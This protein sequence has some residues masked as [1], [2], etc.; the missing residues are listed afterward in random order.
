MGFI[1]SMVGSGIS[2]SGAM[3]KQGIGIWDAETDRRQAKA[4]AKSQQRMMEYNA[5][6]ERR[7]AETV[8]KEYNEQARRL[9]MESENTK[10]A[11]RAGYGKSGV[12]MDSGSPL[13]VMADTSAYLEMEVQDTHRQGERE[14]SKHLVNAQNFMYQARVAKA[15]APR[16]DWVSIINNGM[17]DHVMGVGGA[18]QGAGSTISS[19]KK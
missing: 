5:R 8:Q 16:R 13:A 11:Q 9:R 4:N 12:A 6:L 15:S 17:A 10:S 14:R 1:T 3:H 2:M 7:E 19:N 18:L